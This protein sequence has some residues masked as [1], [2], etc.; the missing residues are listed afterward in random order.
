MISQ[1]ASVKY[2]LF[3]IPYRGRALATLSLQNIVITTLPL[4]FPKAKSLTQLTTD[5]GVVALSVLV[6]TRFNL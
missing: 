2:Y 1:F 6:S 3:S 4:P 5:N